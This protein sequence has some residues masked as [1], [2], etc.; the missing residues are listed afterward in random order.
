MQT[1]SRSPIRT[2]IR[3]I[4]RKTTRS[5]IRGVIRPVIRSCIRC[6]IRPATR[7]LMPCPS[8]REIIAIVSAYYRM[9]LRWHMR[10]N[11]AFQKSRFKTI[12]TPE[13]CDRQM[14]QDLERAYG[15]AK[16]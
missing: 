7:T 2:Q 10:W 14:R 1:R 15:N 3:S 13:D 9:A 12:L 6:G 8:L 5:V 11:P 4:I 16:T